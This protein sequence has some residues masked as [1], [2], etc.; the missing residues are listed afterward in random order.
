MNNLILILITIVVFTSCES[1]E[2]K[3]NEALEEQ[4]H[5]TINK[6]TIESNDAMEFNLYEVEVFEGQTVEL[7]LKHTGVMPLAAM[8]HNWVLLQEGVD[9]YDFGMKAMKATE[10]DY[11]PESEKDKVIAHTKT[12]GG[13]E[14]DTIT[15][16]APNA[17]TYTY[18]C[19]FPNHFAIMKGKMIV[20]PIK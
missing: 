10:T 4:G 20:R 7:T 8:G 14:E 2:S 17:G 11:I 5:S 6:I 13:G 15:F 9:E 3:N 18:C 12:L 1:G 16:K 19:T